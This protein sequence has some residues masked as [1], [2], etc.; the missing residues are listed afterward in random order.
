VGELA[1]TQAARGKGE[2]N[3]DR[4]QQPKKDVDATEN[5]T[6]PSDPV[7]LESPL[8]GRDPTQR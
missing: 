5:P 8:A 7:T 3:S 6:R 4:P 1:E 2:E